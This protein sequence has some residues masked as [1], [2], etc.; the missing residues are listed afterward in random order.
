M[1]QFYCKLSAICLTQ[2]ELQIIKFTSMRFDGPTWTESSSHVITQIRAHYGIERELV[3][4]A[5]CTLQNLQIYYELWIRTV[6]ILHLSGSV[7]SQPACLG[8]KML[9]LLWVAK[10]TRL[11]SIQRRAHFKRLQLLLFL[12]SRKQLKSIFHL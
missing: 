3:W 6:Q 5:A 10:K 8:T 4:C 9:M 2:A 12:Q 1:P 7:V 11:Q